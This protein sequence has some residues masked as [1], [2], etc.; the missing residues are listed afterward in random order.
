MVGVGGVSAWVW[1]VCQR[2]W[3]SKVSRVSDTGENTRVENKVAHYFL[4]FFLKLSRNEYCSKLEKELTFQ[5][6]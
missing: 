3:H 4:N 1:V 5:V 6:I 2:G